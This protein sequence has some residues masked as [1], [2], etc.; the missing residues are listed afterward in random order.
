ARGREL[1]NL[2]RSNPKQAGIDYDAP[3]ILDSLR[4]L[5]ALDYDPQ[6]KGLRSARE[7]VAAYYRERGEQ[8][9]P[10]RLVLTTS[11]SEGY[12]Y[13]FRLL[14]NPGDEVLVP[15]PSYPLFDFLAGLQDVKL[16]PYPLIYDHGWQ[17][18]LH[19]LERAINKRTRAVIVVHPNNP[20]GSY[21]TD[22]ERSALN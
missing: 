7:S 5:K 14:A 8:V 19:A 21:V 10:E 11:T 12:S 15:K 13:I 6:P 2:K 17:I 18:D 3:A 9:A 16:Q 4:N 22:A 1:L 20:T